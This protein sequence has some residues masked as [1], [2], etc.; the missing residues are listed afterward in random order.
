MPQVESLPSRKVNSYK[1]TFSDAPSDQER[2]CSR[3]LVLLVESERKKSEEMEVIQHRRTDAGYRSAVPKNARNAPSAREGGINSIAEHGY[4]RGMKGKH[5]Y[6][7][8]M[9]RCA[10]LVSKG[11][12]VALKP[13]EE[14]KDER[15]GGPE[16]LTGGD[17]CCSLV[18]VLLL[19]V[20]VIFVV[21]SVVIYLASSTALTPSPKDGSPRTSDMQIRLEVSLEDF[22][23]G[24]SVRFQHLRTTLCKH[25]HGRGLNPDVEP[26]PCPQCEGRGVLIRT[27]RMGGM[28]Y[29]QRIQCSSCQGAGV[30]IHEHD[31]CKVCRAQGTVQAREELQV[32]IPI[33]IPSGG[34]VLLEGK[35]NE[36]PGATTGDLFVFLFEKKHPTYK[37]TQDHDL[38]TVLEISLLESL[39]GFRKQVNHL[40][41]ELLEVS[42]SD[43]TPH[44]KVLVIWSG[45]TD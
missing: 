15:K 14:K 12:P 5:L 7:S 31:R 18:V 39:V 20:L 41:R 13:E 10:V 8:K 29:Q 30:H 34:Y 40:S 16:S 26:R 36:H 45:R 11:K 23:F 17:H 25:C 33:G 9:P 32:T 28:T 37:R 4:Q 42:R 27:Q 35:S 3:A 38:E 22:Y 6:S 44:G 2:S 24:S 43:I 1:K 21:P 19:S